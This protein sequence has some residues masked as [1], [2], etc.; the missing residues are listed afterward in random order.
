MTPVEKAERVCSHWPQ[1][2]SE[3][4]THGSQRLTGTQH[5][6]K[7]AVSVWSFESL[8][9]G[10]RWQQQANTSAAFR[11]LLLGP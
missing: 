2:P 4:S 1:E 5:F 9:R 6:D 8:E 7:K 11:L 3:G 10:E